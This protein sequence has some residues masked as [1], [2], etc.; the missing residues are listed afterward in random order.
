ME[1]LPAHL[2][3]VTGHLPMEIGALGGGAHTPTSVPRA[4]RLPCLPWRT[5]LV[6]S[7]TSGSRV[8]LSSPNAVSP[9]RPRPI[10]CHVSQGHQVGA[11]EVCGASERAEVA[12]PAAHCPHAR[13]PGRE[14][15]VAD[16]VVCSLDPQAQPGRGLAPRPK[17]S[18]APV[19]ACC[20]RAL[21][22]AKWASPPTT[23]LCH[24]SLGR[25][26]PGS[27]PHWVGGS[28]LLT[29]AGPGG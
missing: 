21:S 19:G 8:G 16:G 7:C 18:N 17:A 4:P 20:P 11:Q 3:S 12:E 9:C 24:R 26:P 28:C 6:C 15:Q 27:Q 10:A 25:S 14:G 2:P 22:W 1:A 23:A 13:T 29:F 5:Q